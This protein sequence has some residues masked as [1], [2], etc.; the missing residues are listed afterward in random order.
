MSRYLANEEAV[1]R[2][3]N[4]DDIGGIL[5]RVR[6]TFS[7]AALGTIF[8]TAVDVIPA[9]GPGRTILLARA[10]AGKSAGPALTGL[11][12]LL[13]KY[14]GGATLTTIGAAIVAGPGAVKLIYPPQ[15]V[16]ADAV[17]V[18]NTAIT[19]QGSGADAAGGPATITVD[20]YYYVIPTTLGG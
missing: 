15:V 3:V 10:V 2:L 6:R 13:V 16:A 17:P 18:E 7:F 5:Q 4:Q 1:R 11:T 9:P 12:G 8:T 19:I 20:L 14:K